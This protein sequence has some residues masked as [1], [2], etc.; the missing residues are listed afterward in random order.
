M[1][2]RYLIIFL[3]M[4]LLASCSIIFEDDIANEEVY[5]I[6]PRDG[7]ESI[8]Q[9][10]LFWWEPVYG[11]LDYNLQIVSGTFNDPL[12]FIADTMV[13]GDKFSRKLQPGEYEWRISAMNN[14]SSTRYFYSTLTITDTTSVHE[15]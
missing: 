9:E 10:Q 7:A 2:N 1:R 15:E 3:I 5:V 12:G 13:I 4:P 8:V 11:A 6:M 14:F